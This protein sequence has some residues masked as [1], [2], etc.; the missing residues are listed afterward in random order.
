MV[1]EA[2]SRTPSLAELGHLLVQVGIV[3]AR[4]WATA[5]AGGPTDS[6][7]VLD[8]LE[9][10]PAEWLSS[11]PALSRYQ[12]K[13]I[14]KRLAKGLR[15]LDR[16]LRVN[17]F[18]IRAHLGDGG[19]GSVFLA[20][21]IEMRRLVAIKR[22]TSNNPHLR[23]RMA[24]EA[25]ILRKLKHPTI[26]RYVAYEVNDDGDGSVL[27]MEYI[28]GP[29][30]REYCDRHKSVPTEL[31]VGWTVQLLEALAHAHSHGVI[32][33]DLT[34]RN[35]I[36]VTPPDAA[37]FPRLVDFGL[38]KL[39]EATM[40]LTMAQTAI[41]TPQFMPP[42]QFADAANVTAASDLYSLGCNLFLML[43]GRP[44][45][46]GN[47]F[48]ALCLA[49]TN[50]P[51]PRVRD[52]VAVPKHVDAA[53]AQMLS[54]T[55]AARGTVGELVR[56]LTGSSSSSGV[57]VAGAV[58]TPTPLPSTPSAPTPAPRERLAAATPVPERRP[59]FAPLQPAAQAVL[60]P[61]PRSLPP[62]VS[63]AR[64][65]AVAE[66]KTTPSVRMEQVAFDHPQRS[67]WGRLLPVSPL[68]A[69][70]RFIDR[71]HGLVGLL[72]ALGSPWRLAAAAVAVA[73]VIVVLIGIVIAGA[74]AIAG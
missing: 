50:Q 52:L 63:A 38:A 74:R 56:K 31:A 27:A 20:W 30:L 71:D 13:C 5:T 6:S 70:S 47:Q 39:S 9:D 11:E 25:V 55:P 64:E 58:P 73:A 1:R 59:A 72:H 42:E 23:D 57:L 15:D 29:T 69:C 3:S 7:V 28:Q 17:D 67:W 61:P 16:D 22:L 68:A 26:A 37:P 12:R 62:D 44:P 35:I 32:H 66:R 2:D 36:I 45:F 46:E 34:P 10:Q 43:T 4:Q 65:P 24:Q 51:P 54:K 21:S 41:G 60:N 53:V 40:G 8:R 14:E 18:L 33:R 48:P 49:H 19:M